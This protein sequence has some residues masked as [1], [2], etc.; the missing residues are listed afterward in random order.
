MFREAKDRP[1]RVK[2][3]LFGLE[4]RLVR[5]CPDCDKAIRRVLSVLI[6]AK[7]PSD[8]N[9]ATMSGIG[10]HACEVQEINRPSFVH[11]WGLY[12]V[13]TGMACGGKLDFLLRR[14]KAFELEVEC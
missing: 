2:G 3:I 1:V 4:G 6:W 8:I 7:K 11:P 5:K 12:K 9:H 10:L 14:N 13:T